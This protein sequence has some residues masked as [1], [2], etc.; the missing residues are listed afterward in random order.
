MFIFLWGFPGGS[1]AKNLIANVGDTRDAGSI[2]GR[3]D[4]LEE[5]MTTHSSILIWKIPWTEQ[6]GGLQ[7]MGSQKSRTQVSD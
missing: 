5:E 1:V 4:S 6:P 2:P 7:S 3:E